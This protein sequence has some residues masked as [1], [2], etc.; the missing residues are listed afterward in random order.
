M[1]TVPQK[2]IDQFQLTV[3]PNAEVDWLKDGAE[4]NLNA[5]VFEATKVGMLE[6]PNPGMLEYPSP[7][8]L[9]NPKADT[10]EAPYGPPELKFGML[11]I[12][13]VVPVLLSVDTEVE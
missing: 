1:G 2:K 5:R 3:L 6:D 13:N 7:G 11:D 8:V 4:P 9:E 12:P 10:V